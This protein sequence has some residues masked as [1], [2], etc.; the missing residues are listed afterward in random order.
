MKNKDFPLCLRHNWSLKRSF[1]HYFERIIVAMLCD[2]SS[3]GRCTSRSA[4]WRTGSW[5]QCTVREGH[6]SKEVNSHLK[7]MRQFKF[8]LFTHLRY[9]AN[10]CHPQLSVRIDSLFVTYDTPNERC[11]PCVFEG[12]R[13]LEIE[14][15]NGNVP[16]ICVICLGYVIGRSEYPCLKVRSCIM[17]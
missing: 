8:H 6:Q 9:E 16:L 12:S 17:I 5:S 13:Q 1:L 15:H 2:F 11:L 4:L 10:W 3:D 7:K 14:W